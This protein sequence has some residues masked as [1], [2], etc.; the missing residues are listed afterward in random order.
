M[1]GGVGE[2]QNNKKL[3]KNTHMSGLEMSSV[4]TVIGLLRP[5]INLL[6]PLNPLSPNSDQHQISPCNI[7]AYSTPEVMRIKDMITQDEF[8]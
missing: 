4:G 8:S 1:G 5:H 6:G 2:S 3:K 7:N